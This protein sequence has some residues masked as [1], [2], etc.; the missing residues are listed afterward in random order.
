MRT[1][2]AIRR[3][4]SLRQS[5]RGGSLRPDRLIICSRIQESTYVSCNIRI[6]QR[7]TCE[8]VL[9][10]RRHQSIKMWKHNQG[11]SRW[12]IRKSKRGS[13]R[14]KWVKH[15]VITGIRTICMI[16]IYRNKLRVL[17]SILIQTR[18]I[19]TIMLHNMAKVTSTS[20]SKSTRTTTNTT[21]MKSFCREATRARPRLT[22]SRWGGLT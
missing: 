21:R 4:C 22:T 18:K 2:A 7:R 11:S 3:A 14:P 5:C 19:D 6:I 1:R 8:F 13:R 20:Q 9:L 15:R 12:T 16:R 17:L 10:K